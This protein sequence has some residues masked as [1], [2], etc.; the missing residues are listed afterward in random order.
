MS[1]LTEKLITVESRK[2]SWRNV[3]VIELG[4][5]YALWW[6]D[7][8]RLAKERSRW[9]GVVAQPLLFWAVLGSGMAE[10]FAVPNGVADTSYAHYF[11]PGVVVMVML[12]TSIFATM[13]VIED[14]QSGFLQGVLVGPASRW[15]LVWGKISGVVTVTLL[16][17]TLLILVAPLAGFP[18]RQIDWFVLLVMIIL[19]STGLTAMNFAAAW[20]INST[21]GYHALMSIVLLP[22]WMLS[23][24]MFPAPSNWTGTFIALNPMGYLVSAVRS[25]MGDTL[26]LRHLATNVAVLMTF[27]ILSVVTAGRMISRR[28]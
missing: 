27:A 20:R 25:A 26:S 19:G 7:L 10:S 18:Y 2:P 12:F 21:Q 9:L 8:L 4:T 17:C 5:I 15:A 13:S 3:A 24:A 11:F 16:Q 28:R 1:V 6:R 14:R 22:M 23:G